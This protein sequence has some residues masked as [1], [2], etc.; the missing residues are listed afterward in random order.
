MTT[1][2]YYAISQKYLT[3]PHIKFFYSKKA[4][5]KWCE[6]KRVLTPRR[7]VGTKEARK[8]MTDYVT[9]KWD[10]EK[11]YSAFKCKR[12]ISYWTMQELR[13]IYEYLYVHDPKWLEK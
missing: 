4:R 8:I 11:I 7:P 13:C 10:I 9:R 12:E 5:D 2:M 3:E 1:T 6:Q